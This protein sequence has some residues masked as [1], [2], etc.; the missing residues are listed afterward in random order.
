L[1]AGY[2][3][4]GDRKGGHPDRN[5]NLMAQETLNSLASEGFIA[6]PGQMGEQ[7]I[8][9]GLVQDLNTLPAGTQLQIGTQA[10]IELVK[11]RTGCER[12]EAIQGQSPSKVQARMGVMARVLTGGAIQVGDGVKIL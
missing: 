2:G 7:L 5:L 6:G 9:D 1:I 11:P 12:F 10:V 4:E 3:I 8:V